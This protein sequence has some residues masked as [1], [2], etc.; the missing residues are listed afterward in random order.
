VRHELVLVDNSLDVTANLGVGREKVSPRRVGS[1]GKGVE[2]CGD[3]T[4]LLSDIMRHKQHNTPQRTMQ[5][6]SSFCER[7]SQHCYTYTT[8]Q[9]VTATL[10]WV[11]INPPCSR[12]PVVSVV[13]MHVREVEAVLALQLHAEAE[14]T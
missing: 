4:G 10:T 7:Q 1:E 11:P 9:D 8:P 3:V 6:L 5:R 13:K 2:C 14:A 12:I